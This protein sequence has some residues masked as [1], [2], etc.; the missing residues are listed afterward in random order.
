MHIAS[1]LPL[2]AREMGL[3]DVSVLGRGRVRR[4]I[5]GLVLLA[6]LALIGCLLPMM[7]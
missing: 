1:R 2:V 3:S 4:M 6:V 7:S 5:P